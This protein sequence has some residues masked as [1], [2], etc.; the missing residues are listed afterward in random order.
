MKRNIWGVAVVVVYAAFALSTLGFVAFAMTQ[1]VDLVSPDYYQRSLVEDRRIEA[2]T[3]THALGNAVSVRV[4]DAGSAI[5]IR[6]P[7][8]DAVGTVT[9]YRPSGSAA[10]RTIELALLDRVQTVPAAGL[11]AGRWLVQMA[12]T[13]G[14]RSYYHE[15][16]IALR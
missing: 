13:T 5:V 11:P 10:D 9:F 1:P 15:E 12:W 7:F 2:R 8:D 3:N 14:G 4:N 6:V 16:G